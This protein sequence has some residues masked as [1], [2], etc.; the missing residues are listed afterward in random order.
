[1]NTTQQTSAGTG[2]LRDRQTKD[3][4]TSRSLRVQAGNFS[5]SDV[6]RENPHSKRKRQRKRKRTCSP[7]RDEQKREV[8]NKTPSVRREGAIVENPATATTA[9]RTA[10]RQRPYEPC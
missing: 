9:H 5:V 4:P 10:Q 7:H 2:L 6:R 1:M 3:E 8:E